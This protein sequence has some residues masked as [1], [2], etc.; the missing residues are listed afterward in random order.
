MSDKDE[1]EFYLNDQAVVKSPRVE[2]SSIDL[3]G[4]P[5]LAG[6][7]ESEERKSAAAFESFVA[8][9]R[10]A[11]ESNPVPDRSTHVVATRR[12]LDQID[13]VARDALSSGRPFDEVMRQRDAS[14]NEVFNRFRAARLQEYNRY[15]RHLSDYAHVTG[16]LVGQTSARRWHSNSCTIHAPSTDFYIA[17][18]PPPRTTIDSDRGTTSVGG[19]G[20]SPDNTYVTVTINARDRY[21]GEGVS[22]IGVTLYASV[23][24]RTR[25]AEAQTAADEAWLRANVT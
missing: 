11:S 5:D 19:I 6:S 21:R 3:P 20:I 12:A 2:S 23:G 25:Y 22:G 8:A 24:Y 9:A 18:S 7:E 4:D 16:D 17:G 13:R 10:L 1:V 15:R 14:R